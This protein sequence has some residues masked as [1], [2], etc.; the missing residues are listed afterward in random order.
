M[1]TRICSLAKWHHLLVQL[2]VALQMIASPPVFLTP[3]SAP[4]VECIFS[5]WPLTCGF[6]CPTDLHGSQESGFQVSHA[7]PCFS[8]PPRPSFWLQVCPINLGA[9][10]KVADVTA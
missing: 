6:S 8:P 4:C 1:E 5:L 7:S 3:W 2:G 10:Q 9:L